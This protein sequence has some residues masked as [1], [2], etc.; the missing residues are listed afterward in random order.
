MKFFRLLF[1][2]SEVL[3]DET[4]LPGRR[5]TPNIWTPSGLDTET[6][7]SWLGLLCRFWI[8]Q[9]D[10]P[11]NPEGD[12]PLRLFVSAHLCGTESHSDDLNLWSSREQILS[13]HTDRI[14][15]I[16]MGSPSVYNP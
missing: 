4:E 12:C 6:G 2:Y 14:P 13:R 15:H 5:A 1:L 10:E 16:Y 8:F 7:V 3:S 9:T 11:G